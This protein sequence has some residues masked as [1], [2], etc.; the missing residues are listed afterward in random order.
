MENVI[1]VLGQGEKHVMDFEIPIVKDVY[2][3]NF[4]LVH[5]MNEKDEPMD[6]KS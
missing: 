4:E 5:L 6:G 3:A 2:L 1:Q